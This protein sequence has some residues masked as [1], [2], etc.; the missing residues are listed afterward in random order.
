MGGGAGPPVGSEQASVS[1][2]AINFAVHQTRSGHSGARED[3]EQ[4]LALLVQATEPTARL[5]A[6][7]PGDWGIDVVVGELDGDD[8]ALFQAKY[9]YPVVGAKQ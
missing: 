8:V 4:M 6:A 9:F 2:A 5:I 7:N 3:F 1:A